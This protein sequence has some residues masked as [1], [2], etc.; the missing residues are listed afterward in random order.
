MKI[1]LIGPQGSGKGT[2]GSLLSDHLGIPFISGGDLLRDLSEN[3]PYYKEASTYMEKG[4]LVPIDTMSSIIQ[5]RISHED[6]AKGFIMDGWCRRMDDLKA[7]DPEFD[8]VFVLDI[9]HDTS[10]KRITGRRICTSDEKTYNIYTLPKEELE[11]CT[12]ELIQREDDTKE[13]VEIRLNIYYTQTQKVIDYFE[14]QGLLN[15]I[16]GEGM[17]KEVFQNALS[18]LESL[19]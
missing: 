3:S 2:L 10:I 14:K 15:V 18:V 9:S 4:L 13:A 12:G 19:S 17:P 7:L 1:L 16:D 11:E 6:C 5:E 8:L